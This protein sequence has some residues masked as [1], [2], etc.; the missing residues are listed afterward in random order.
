MLGPDDHEQIAHA[1]GSNAA[2]LCA[3]KKHFDPDGVF[4]AIPL[5]S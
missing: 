2:R 4:S 5:P 3:A 1:Y